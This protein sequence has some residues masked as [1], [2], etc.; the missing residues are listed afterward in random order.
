MV[1]KNE[2]GHTNL[3]I[4]MQSQKCLVVVDQIAKYGVNIQHLSEQ[5]KSTNLF[6]HDDHCTYS[7]FSNLNGV[8]EWAKYSSL[9]I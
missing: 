5:S 3:F 9:F 6:R 7:E 1:K 4:I 8:G 2:Q